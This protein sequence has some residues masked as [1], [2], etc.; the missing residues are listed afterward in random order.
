MFTGKLVP[1]I[2]IHH[3]VMLECSLKITV[4]QSAILPFC[5]T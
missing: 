1:H 4:I 3:L 5:S 2:P